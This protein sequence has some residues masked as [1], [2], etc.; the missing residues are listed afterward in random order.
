[1]SH[2]GALMGSEAKKED[3]SHRRRRADGTVVLKIFSRQGF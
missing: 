3:N 1:M 2:T